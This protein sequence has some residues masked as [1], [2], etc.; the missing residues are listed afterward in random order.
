YGLSKQLIEEIARCFV[1]RGGVEIVTLRPTLIL[2]PG[3][4]EHVR[5]LRAGDDPDLWSYVEVAGV[6]QA[7]PRALELRNGREIEVFFLSAADTYAAAPT[8]E[9]MARAF[10]GLP[11]IR[12]PEIYADN[13][14]AAIWDLSRAQSVLGF[15]PESDWRRFIGHGEELRV[16]S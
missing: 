14:F 12:K 13:P 2:M 8:L 15:V 6:V 11:P 9:F 7:I 16:G 1:R 10:G 4:E 5:R 3:M